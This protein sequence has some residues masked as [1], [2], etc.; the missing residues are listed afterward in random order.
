MEEF[1]K[2]TIKFTRKPAKMGRTYIFVIPKNYIEDG[3]IDVDVEYEI[4]LKV[5]EKNEDGKN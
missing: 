4:Y 3:L 1:H 2:A 5:K